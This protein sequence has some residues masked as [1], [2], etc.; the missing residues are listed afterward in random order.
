MT[1]QLISIVISDPGIIISGRI[2]LMTHYI[3][4]II[5]ITIVIIIIVPFMARN[6]NISLTT[7]YQQTLILHCK[8][9][10]FM[11]LTFFPSMVCRLSSTTRTGT[12]R[13]TSRPWTAPIGWD[14]PSR[15]R[16]TG[17]FARPPSRSESCRGPGRRAR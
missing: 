8:I 12:R 17:W 3:M 7:C 9:I 1:G 10:I 14:R 15:S 2:T 6:K 11:L 16:C 4:I 5:M 13:W